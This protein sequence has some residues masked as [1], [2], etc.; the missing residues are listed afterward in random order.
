MK[1]EGGLLFVTALVVVGL[2]LSFSFVVDKRITGN[3]IWD[4]LPMGIVECDADFNHDGIVDL[5]DFG[6]LKS[7]YGMISGA[8]WGN[9]DFNEDG[10]VDLQDF[11]LLKAHYGGSR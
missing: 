8:T 3:V 10:A 2:V 6:I 4:Q 9:G 1:K 11:G 5:Q 7:H